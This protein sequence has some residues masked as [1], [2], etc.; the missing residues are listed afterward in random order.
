MYGTIDKPE[1][2]DPKGEFFCK[3][4][5]DWMP[6]IHGK[7]LLSMLGMMVLMLL[8]Q[9]F[10]TSKSSKENRGSEMRSLT[11]VATVEFV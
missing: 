10:S 4:R 1:D 7:I 3:Y 11:V 2:L 6:E 5:E 9:E 8:S